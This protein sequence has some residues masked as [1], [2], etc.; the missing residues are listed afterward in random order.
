MPVLNFSHNLF[1]KRHLCCVHQKVQVMHWCRLRDLCKGDGDSDL[2]ALF[3]QQ[4]SAGAVGFAAK[5]GVPLVDLRSHMYQVFSSLHF[6][7]FTTLS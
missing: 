5:S 4:I 7:C 2:V 1:I 6:L 3:L